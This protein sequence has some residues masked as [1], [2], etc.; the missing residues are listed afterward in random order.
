MLIHNESIH[1]MAFSERNK[2]IVTMNFIL[3]L[4]QKFLDLEQSGS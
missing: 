2:E 4:N 3:F 1:D